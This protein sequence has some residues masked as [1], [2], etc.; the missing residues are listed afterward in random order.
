MEFLSIE[1]TAKFFV[2]S[3]ITFYAFKK[4]SADF[5][6]PYKK[7]GKKFYAKSELREWAKRHRILTVEDK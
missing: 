4:K 3:K 7:G 1:N 6:L 2:K 5:P